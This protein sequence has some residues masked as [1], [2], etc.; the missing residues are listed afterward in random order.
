MGN[1]QAPSASQEVSVLD[2]N[3]KLLPDNWICVASSSVPGEKVYENSFTG[4]F[5]TRGLTLRFTFG[6]G[7][8]AG[9]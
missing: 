7:L 6:G 5:H 8:V 9:G 2:A 1:K 3:G 4:T